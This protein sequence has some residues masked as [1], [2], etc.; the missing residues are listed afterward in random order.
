MIPTLEASP[1]LVIGN[2]A[3]NSTDIG[4]V[5]GNAALISQAVASPERDGRAL[6]RRDDPVHPGRPFSNLDPNV[7]T[8]A[9]ESQNADEENPATRV[10]ATAQST[11]PDAEGADGL[12]EAERRKVQ[13]LQARDREV[14]E[15][16]A[17]HKTAGGAYASAPSFR[18]VSGPDGRSYAVGG[19]V[20]IDTSSVPNN[21]EATIRK[22]QTVKRAALAPRQP[23]SQ[24]HAV[25]A[26]A[27][28]K[29]LQA[30]QQLQRERIEEA[31]NRSTAAVQ[32]S[33]R[34]G[35][36]S[37]AKG[38]DGE[39]IFNP[40]KRFRGEKFG[41]GEVDTSSLPGS[42]VLSS[43]GSGVLNPGQLLSLVA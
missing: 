23:S 37:I 4:R 30:R 22:L 12:T 9:Q 40:E 18:T 15:H 17:A 16:E 2:P 6:I 11:D 35:A 10:D 43:G 1:P 14:R 19:E 41:I 34:G 26:Q 8:Q 39:P 38:P 42:G 36:K 24:D 33:E 31:Q 13:E 21:P 28:Q 25:A 20:H 3:L 29:I 5:A 32:G 27:E 7:Q